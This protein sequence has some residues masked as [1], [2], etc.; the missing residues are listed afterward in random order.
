MCSAADEATLSFYSTVVGSGGN[1]SWVISLPVERNATLNQSNLY[2]AAWLGL[3]LSDPHGWLGECFVEVQLY[4]D[5]SFYNPGSA[6]AARTVPGSWVGAVVGWQFDAA[7]GVE[8]ACFYQPLYL[9]GNPGPAF[10]N[11]TQGDRLNLTTTGWPGNPTGEVVSVKDVTNGQSSRVTL[12][13]A[14]GNYPLDPVYATNAFQDALEWRAGGE[15]PISFGFDLGRSVN[16]AVVANGTGGGCAPGL[17][18]TPVDPSAPCPSYDPG[19]WANDTLTPWHIGTPTFFN[20]LARAKATQVG[21][22]STTGGAGGV[23]AASGGACTGRVGSA[24]CSYPWFSYSCS[25]AAFEFGAADFGGITA[26]F[27]KYAE[28][29]PVLQHNSLGLSFAAPRN[30][31]VPGCGATS[32]TVTVHQR[33]TPTAAVYFLGQ[34]ISGEANVSGV[35]NGTYSAGA[36]NAPGVR[37][38]FWDPVGNISVASKGDPFTSVTVFGNGVLVAFFNNNPPNATKV[39]FNDAPGGFVAVDPG[40]TFV[41]PLGG[42][43]SSLGTLKTGAKLTLLPGLY[44][45]SAIPTRGFAFSTWSVNNTGATLAAPGLPVTWLSVTSL[46]HAVTVIAHYVASPSKAAVRVI[47]VGNGTVRLASFS[48]TN[49]GNASATGTTTLPL[50]GYPLV[51]TLGTGATGVTWVASPLA[52]LVNFSATTNA[53]LQG[54]TTIEAIFGHAATVT[55]AEAPPTGGSVSIVG[56]GGPGPALANGTA[57]SL[58]PGSYP[59]QANLRGGFAFVAWSTSGG[60]AVNPAGAPVA[61]LTVTGP[62]TVTA[63]FVKSTHVFVVKIGAQAS[64]D[65]A[66][67]WDG[68]GS[69]GNLT[70]NKAV[71]GGLHLAS[72]VAAQGWAF[73]GWNLSGKVSL[74]GA[75]G[76]LDQ[77]VNVTGTAQVEAL[78]APVISP[79]TFVVVAT[80]PALPLNVTLTINGVVLTTGETTLLPTA[81]Y[82]ARISG[83]TTAVKVWIVTS[84]LTLVS[85][86]SGVANITVAGSGT[87]YVLLAS[88]KGS[89]GLALSAPPSAA[90]TDPALTAGR[91]LLRRA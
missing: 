83:N 31:T 18:S 72:A 68:G 3:A 86:G 8:D 10:L 5:Q 22:A 54:P 62:G 42:S 44:T 20:A 14:T 84:N 61:T 80:S 88:S 30:F 35:V 57:Q 6:G 58:L 64:S 39:T 27:G 33:G 53:T 16:G 45:I 25:A 91:P 21:F 47:A 67:V 60:V 9:N 11:M 12:F 76:A 51:A 43:G 74:V 59:L 82:L 32:F 48:L 19:A 70:A 55:F 78:F 87:I 36:I 46:N 7:T 15:Y 24:A 85:T 81:T 2:S 69:F 41:G 79:V 23:G 38:E 56:A 65:G 49:A 1:V 37:F 34:A 50:G 71:A 73:S 26:D 13:N 52:N 63:S 17:T 75:G 90:P 28:F 4:P 66:V 29:N 89:G 40:M 77:L